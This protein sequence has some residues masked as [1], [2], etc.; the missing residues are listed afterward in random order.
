ML[1]L[2]HLARRRFLGRTLAAGAAGLAGPPLVAATAAEVPPYLRD[3]G[4][5]IGCW[6]RPWANY[7]YR[8]AMDA[9]AAVRLQVHRSHGCE[10]EDQAGDRTGNHDR[11][12]ATGG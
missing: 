2:N 7:D 9:V 5:L 11:G 3:R 1:T 8:V 4:W 12:I 6:T 10:N